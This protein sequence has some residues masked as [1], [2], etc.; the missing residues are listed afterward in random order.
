[1]SETVNKDE[2]IFFRILLFP[3]GL[4]QLLINTRLTGFEGLRLIGFRIRQ[5]EKFRRRIKGHDNFR[6]F[7][8]NR[9]Q[10]LSL[11]LE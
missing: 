4:I 8:S 2:Q 5:S 3:L 10:K 1:M 11:M 7:L 9:L 6:K